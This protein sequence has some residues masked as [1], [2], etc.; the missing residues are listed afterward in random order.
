MW[1]GGWKRIVLNIAILLAT[2]AIGG[3]LWSYVLYRIF[4]GPP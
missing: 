1:S 4:I 3:F 2:F